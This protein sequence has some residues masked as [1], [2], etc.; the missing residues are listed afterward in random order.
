MF[1]IG[2]AAQNI[3]PAAHSLDLG[4]AIIGS[5][6]HNRIKETLHLPAKYEMVALITMGYLAHKIPYSHRKEISVFVY[7]ETF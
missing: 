6:D 5:F 2:L 1:D 4:T 7:Y 3:C